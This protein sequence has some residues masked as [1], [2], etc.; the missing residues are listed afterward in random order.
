[1]MARASRLIF[2]ENP[3][4]I[5]CFRGVSSAKVDCNNVSVKRKSKP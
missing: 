1:M 3:L 5:Y 2:R 4:S